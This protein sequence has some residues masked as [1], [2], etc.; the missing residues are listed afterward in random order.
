MTEIYE[1]CPDRPIVLVTG[2]RFHGK[3]CSWVN[4]SVLGDA[5]QG[6]SSDAVMYSLDNIIN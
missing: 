6:V 4:S 3:W 5:D 2:F 1:T